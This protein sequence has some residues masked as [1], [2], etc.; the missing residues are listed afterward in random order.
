MKDITWSFDD[1]QPRFRH[2]K[3]RQPFE[4]QLSSTPFTIQSADPLFSLPLGEASEKFVYWLTPQAIWD[5]YRSLSQISVL[6]GEELAVSAQK[7]LIRI[8]ADGGIENREPGF[9]SSPR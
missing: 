6:E 3:W 1:S 8:D 9:R 5:R 7:R 4:K 2:E